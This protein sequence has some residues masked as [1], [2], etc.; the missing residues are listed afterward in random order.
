MFGNLRNM[1]S[2]YLT[3]N[4]QIL[5]LYREGSRVI[6]QVWLGSAGGHFEPQECNDARA[7]IL[8]EMYEELGINEQQISRLSLRYV[9]LRYTAG[10]LRQNYYFFADLTDSSCLPL[11]SNEGRL[12]WFPLKDIQALPMPFTAKYVI[13]H[14]LKTG[15]YTEQMYGGVAD[16]ERVFF[17]AMPES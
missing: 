15:R 2:I 1:T 3:R 7:C 16:G 14:W 5:L 17:T 11:L 8:R 6:N 4:D 10:E 13:Q 9:T 12:Q